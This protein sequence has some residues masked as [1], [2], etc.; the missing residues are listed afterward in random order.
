MPWSPLGAG[1]L[2]GKIDTS[3]AID[4]K[5]FRANSPR[6][7]AE[8]REA[9]ST[10]VD[11]LR[12]VAAEKGATPAQVA[13]AW[14]LAKKPWIVPIFGTRRLDR[15]T[16]NLGATKID[17]TANDLSKIEVIGSSVKVQ[18]ARLAEAMLRLSYR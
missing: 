2:T 14:L 17:L 1:F 15:V 10:I 11:L 4:P 13:L 12:R 5:D 9:N 16:E 6:F 8:A 3:T 18:G 7:T